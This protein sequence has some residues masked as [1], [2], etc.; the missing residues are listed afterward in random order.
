MPAPLEWCARQHLLAAVKHSR[1]C[2][3]VSEGARVVAVAK[4]KYLG[5]S[6]VTRTLLLAPHSSGLPTGRAGK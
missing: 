1:R 3:P 4:H 6:L 2:L 5:G